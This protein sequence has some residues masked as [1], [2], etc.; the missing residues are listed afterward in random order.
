MYKFIAEGQP[1]EGNL[2]L[3][4]LQ[5][6]DYICADNPRELVAGYLR[7]PDYT[8]IQDGGV[9]AYI[10]QKMGQD[11]RDMA[12]LSFRRVFKSEI[13]FS[14]DKEFLKGLVLN[15]IAV[16]YETEGS[17]RVRPETAD[18]PPASH[19]CSSCVFDTGNEKCSQFE[20]W[21]DDD[22]ENCMGFARKNITVESPERILVDYGHPEIFIED[23]WQPATQAEIDQFYAEHAETEN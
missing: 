15:G 16:I 20:A 18:L 2:L 9:S 12:P 7:N 3:I 23:Y 8:D 1:Y 10:R 21:A 22:G 13:G 19:C 11:L 14:T 6:G 5:T 17:Y 4:D